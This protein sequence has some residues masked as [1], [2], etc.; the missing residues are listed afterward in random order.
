ME[1]VW[2]DLWPQLYVLQACVELGVFQ[3]CV[4]WIVRFGLCEV[5]LGSDLRPRGPEFRR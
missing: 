1:A 5:V 2:R 4:L 3:D